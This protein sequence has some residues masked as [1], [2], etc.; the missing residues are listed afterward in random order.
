MRWRRF[1]IAGPIDPGGQA[2]LCQTDPVQ[3]KARVDAWYS[4][5]NGR[6][7]SR[8]AQQ[9]EPQSLMKPD[10]RQERSNQCVMDYAGH[11]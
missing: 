2:A 10:S 1:A 7:A 4:G 3:G 5:D 11:I 8:A 9:L 6:L